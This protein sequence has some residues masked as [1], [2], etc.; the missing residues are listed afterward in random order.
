MLMIGPEGSDGHEI[1]SV[2]IG[3][4]H[5]S[6]FSCS[7]LQAFY[8]GLVVDGKKS[9][10]VACFPSTASMV[11]R[12]GPPRSKKMAFEDHFDVFGTFGLRGKMPSL[13]LICNA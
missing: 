8:G 12:P 9:H 3:L 6:F 13:V 5:C 4:P 1:F 10:N 2:Y 11:Y 7:R